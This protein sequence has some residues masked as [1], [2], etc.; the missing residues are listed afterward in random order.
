MRL[1]K[2]PGECGDTNAPATRR[3]NHLGLFLTP[4]VNP[5]FEKYSDFQKY[6]ITSYCRRPVPHRG[7]F[8]DRHGRWSGMRWTLTVLKTRAPEADGEVV[9]F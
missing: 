9:W 1:C 3:A 6:Q 5:I 7:A 8:R 2:K 4:S